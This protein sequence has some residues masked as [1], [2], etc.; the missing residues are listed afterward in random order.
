MQTWALWFFSGIIGL[1]SFAGCATKPDPLS[2]ASTNSWPCYQLSAEKSW[3]LDLPQGERFDASALLLRKGGE[4]LTVNDRGAAVYKI[5]FAS[6]APSA[7]LVCLTNCFAAARL[8]RF[9]R[10]KVDRYDCE[11]LAQDSRG[12]IYLCEEANRWILRCDPKTGEVERLAIDWAPVKQYFHPSDR[13]ASFEGIA[14]GGG[15]LF[16]ANERQEGRIIVVDLKSL[17]IVDDF[18][19]R[20][21]KTQ[22]QDIHYSDLSWHDGALFALLRDNRVV[23]KIDPRNHRV[24]AEYSFYAMEQQPDLIY[25]TTYPTSTM[26]GL[27]VDKDF[28][29]L[30]TDNNG[31]GRKQFPD[32]KRPTLFKCRRPDK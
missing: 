20:P 12:W 16:V 30:V 32:D 19:V 22:M 27:A 1:I 25:R 13:N 28:F 6:N 2:Q 29:W 15:K 9:D 18:T 8:A 10:E 11:G 14:I 23:V 4:L 21:S 26:E 24:L 17:K 5:Q 31:W 7:R 3:Q